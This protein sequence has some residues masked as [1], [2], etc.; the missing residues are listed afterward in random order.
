MLWLT[1]VAILIIPALSQQ[2]PV[3]EIHW[4]SNPGCPDNFT[5]W[6]CNETQIL[7]VMAK[8]PN[9]TINYL[10]AFYS[11]PALL[12]AVTEPEARLQIDW[13][14]LGNSSKRLI[15]FDPQPTYSFG[16]VLDRII[17]FYDPLDKADMTQ[18]NSSIVWDC[19]KFSWTVKDVTSGVENLRVELLGNNYGNG[20]K[21]G[22][23]SVVLSAF[24]RDGYGPLLPHMQ[25]SNN[26]SQVEITLKNLETSEDFKSES[27]FG[28]QLMVVDSV[29]GEGM[30]EV[31]HRRSLDD[32]HTPGVFDINTLQTPEV[33]K[34]EAG[35]YMEWRPVAY[36][37]PVRAIE[38]STS[39][40]HYPLRNVSQAHLKG[41]LLHDFYGHNLA[42]VLVPQSLNISFGIAED[43]FYD[44][45]KYNAWTFTMAY[46]QPPKDKFSLL[47]I[48]ILAVGLGLPTVIFV[49]GGTY[50]C[51]KK[52]RTRRD[53]PL[54]N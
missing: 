19:R 31:F 6:D 23:V 35:G 49:F 39:A 32:E 9:D 53:E 27:R 21:I 14:Q 18:A 36:T 2:D 24:G 52:C 11:K 41:T 25:H 7:H 33:R 30:D 20:S 3:R 51:V 22:N 47:V 10:W 17:E 5:R 1:L 44:A 50:M 54:V 15:R 37:S 29:P 16:L 43:G 13:N 40:V 8:G 28:L 12:M 4:A 34:G 38:E 46:G 42:H 26:A 45:T 48:M